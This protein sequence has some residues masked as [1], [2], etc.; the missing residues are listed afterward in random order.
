MSILFKEFCRSSLLLSFLYLQFFGK[1]KFPQSGM[2]AVCGFPRSGNTYIGR[3]IQY[4]LKDNVRLVDHFH[5]SAQLIRAVKLKS[6]SILCVRDVENVILSPYIGSVKRNGKR[7]FITYHFIRYIIY[8]VVLLKYKSRFDIVKL[9]DVQDDPSPLLT[10]M[11][12]K[13]G[14]ELGKR[15][16]R[17]EIV[18]SIRSDMQSSDTLKSSAPN[19]EKEELKALFRKRVRRNW[20]FPIAK[21]IEKT[22]LK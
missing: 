7:I 12:Q 22:L 6:P 4:G 2:I 17:D 16:S 19:R 13:Y 10:F 1:G 20:L 3:I 5:S 21:K 9:E 11:R 14:Y 15:V 8:H 18:G